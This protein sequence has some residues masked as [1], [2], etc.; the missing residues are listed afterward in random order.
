MEHTS[1]Y[2]Y[3]NDLGNLRDAM[4]GCVLFSQKDWWP[5][6]W[7]KKTLPSAKR[8]FKVLQT[9]CGWHSLTSTEGLVCWRVSGFIHFLP[10]RLKV[11][12]T[13]ALGTLIC[14]LPICSHLSF[15]FFFFFI[16]LQFSD[17][18]SRCLRV[19]FVLSLFLCWP[20]MLQ[21][22]IWAIVTSSCC[23]NQIYF[24]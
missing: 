17:L 5:T 21:S 12:E 4:G 20:D 3:G 19:F 7:D 10:F 22:T 6:V 2:L 1:I 23:C 13:L 24:T 11:L 15:Y 9:C 18:S 16:V 8:R 14:C